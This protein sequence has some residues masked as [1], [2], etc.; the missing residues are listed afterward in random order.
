MYQGTSHCEFLE[1]ACV[2]GNNNNVRGEKKDCKMKGQ[3][4]LFVIFSK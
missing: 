2:C 1:K 3:S 4:F